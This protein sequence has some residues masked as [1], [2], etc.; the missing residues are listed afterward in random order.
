M[1]GLESQEGNVNEIPLQIHFNP[2]P[3]KAV[4]AVVEK[5]IELEPEDINE[6]IRD[7]F[8]TATNEVK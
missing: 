6:A 5:N 8:I 4:V 1:E 7:I 2:R 3:V